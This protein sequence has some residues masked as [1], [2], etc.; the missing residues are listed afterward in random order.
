[1]KFEIT[2]LKK[3]HSKEFADDQNRGMFGKI[4]GTTKIKNKGISKTD[5]NQKQREL[6][7]TQGD[8][9]TEGPHKNQKSAEIKNRRNRLILK[10]DFPYE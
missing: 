9:K 6:K 7:K 4:E 2:A 8:Q 3:T 1:L 5:G 10:S